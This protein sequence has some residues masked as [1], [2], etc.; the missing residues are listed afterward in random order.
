MGGRYS[1]TRA[2]GGQLQSLRTEIPA[3]VYMP[4]CM[5]RGM[6]CVHIDLEFSLHWDWKLKP[7]S[8]SIDHTLIQILNKINGVHA[9]ELLHAAKITSLLSS[10]VASKQASKQ[11]ICPIYSEE[12]CRWLSSQERSQIHILWWSWLSRVHGCTVSVPA[13]PKR[14]SELSL[15]QTLNFPVLA[16]SFSSM[17]SEDASALKV[18]VSA[19]ITHDHVKVR[20]ACWHIFHCPTSYQSCHCQ[21]YGHSSCLLQL[22]SLISLVPPL[23][24]PVSLPQQHADWQVTESHCCCLWH[25]RNAKCMVPLKLVGQSQ[26]RFL[27]VVCYFFWPWAW[28][29]AL[30]FRIRDCRCLGKYIKDNPS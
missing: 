3:W 19:S 6:W 27:K 28:H 13:Y 5:G 1:F 12:G 4:Q 29:R 9:L 24:T 15:T 17:Q 26:T 25:S 16:V 30:Q 21:T 10:S 2:R 23:V 20:Q 8:L 14:P 7:C 11:S 22:P 18:S